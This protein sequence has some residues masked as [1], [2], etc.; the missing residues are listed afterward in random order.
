[1]MSQLL[2]E[3]GEWETAFRPLVNHLSDNAS[4]QGDDGRGI[5]FE[6]YGQEL[7][8]VENCER[9]C[10]WTYLDLDSDLHPTG[11]D[12]PVL[13]SGMFPPRTGIIG[14]FVTQVPVPNHTV[15]TVLVD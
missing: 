11:E 3:V 13:M 9:A 4:W 8:F 1:M 5:M 15:A 12:A 10:V 7:E 6:T 14:Y 2:L